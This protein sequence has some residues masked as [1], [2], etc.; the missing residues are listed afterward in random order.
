MN[1]KVTLS[2]GRTAMQIVD[3]HDEQVSIRIERFNPYSC[4]IERCGT[5]LD[6]KELIGMLEP[7]LKYRTRTEA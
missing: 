2:N 7:L 4:K 1:E 6:H 3:I 5:V